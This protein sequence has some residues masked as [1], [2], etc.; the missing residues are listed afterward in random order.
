MLLSAINYRCVL[1]SAAH[2]IYWQNV[3]LTFTCIRQSLLKR[4]QVGRHF[5]AS[6]I[7]KRYNSTVTRR[8]ALIDVQTHAGHSIA[9]NMF[10]CNWWPCDLWPKNHITYRISQGHSLHTLG[11]FV[12]ELGLS[13]MRTHTQ[14]ESQTDRQTDRRRWALYSRDC[15]RREWL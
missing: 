4:Q 7:F 8:W 11:S 5:V 15:R 10:F 9:F 3:N 2:T 14:T 6:D 13:C 1:E 12:F